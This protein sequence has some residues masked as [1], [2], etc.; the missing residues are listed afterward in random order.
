MLLFCSVE[1]VDTE[2]SHAVKNNQPLLRMFEAPEN[3]YDTVGRVNTVIE[4]EN[5][6]NKQER[7]KT[8]PR[9]KLKQVTLK[10]FH[11]IGIYYFFFQ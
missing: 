10:F 1:D 3:N 4:D 11:F 9:P 6:H 8:R 2:M 7:A 5:K